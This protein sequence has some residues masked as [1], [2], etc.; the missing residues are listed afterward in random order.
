MIEGQAR[1]RARLCGPALRRE[2]FY[3]KLAA[4]TMPD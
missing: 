1:R 3:A 2:A 4:V